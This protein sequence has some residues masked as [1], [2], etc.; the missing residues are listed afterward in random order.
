MRASPHLGITARRV[1][2]VLNDWVLRGI[3][4]E[5]DGSQSVAYFGMVPGVDGMVRVAVS[6]DDAV[7]ITAFRDR[8]ATRHWNR[9]NLNYFT[10]TYTDL[11]ARDEGQ[12]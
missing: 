10:L 8:T 5:R 2:R 6:L 4:T 7:I 3:R 9:G 12:L 11:E 1:E